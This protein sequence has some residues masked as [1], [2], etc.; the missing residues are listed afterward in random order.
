MFHW[1]SLIKTHTMS[2][3]K[4]ESLVAIY[5]PAANNF[6][7]KRPMSLAEFMENIHQLEFP[8]DILVEMFRKMKRDISHLK[9]QYREPTI[10]PRLITI[11]P[12]KHNTSNL[13]Q[14]KDARHCE[15]QCS[16]CS[17]GGPGKTYK[18]FATIFI[19]LLE[20]IRNAAQNKNSK[21]FLPHILHVL[22]NGSLEVQQKC[23][24][25]EELLTPSDVSYALLDVGTYS[26]VLSKMEN[27]FRTEVHLENEIP[28]LAKDRF[29]VMLIFQ[30]ICSFCCRDFEKM[31]IMAKNFQ[32][33]SLVPESL[34]CF[35]GQFVIHFYE[36]LKASFF[37]DPIKNFAKILPLVEESPEIDNPHVVGTIAENKNGSSYVFLSEQPVHQ[38]NE[39]SYYQVRSINQPLEDFWMIYTDE[40]ICQKDIHCK[41][42]VLHPCDKF[43]DEKT[44]YV[45]KF[46]QPLQQLVSTKVLSA[47]QIAI[48]CEKYQ[49]LLDSFSGSDDWKFLVRYRNQIVVVRDRQIPALENLMD[50]HQNYSLKIIAHC[51]D[52]KADGTMIGGKPTLAAG[53]FDICSPEALQGRGLSIGAIHFTFGSFLRIMLQLATNT[54]LETD[55]RLGGSSVDLVN[56]LMA[57]DPETRECCFHQ[58]YFTEESVQKIL[59]EILRQT[60]P[61]RK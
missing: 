51:P 47:K 36:S 8:K 27:W 23:F 52:D 30:N 7:F 44:A 14:Y 17:I 26:R 49:D 15:T 59:D 61:F 13:L 60:F 21:S 12:Y 33:Y 4:T 35:C 55:T 46:V 5:T 41:S 58:T 19:N 48:L 16:Y 18:R 6:D 50:S 42:A 11:N 39:L 31:S 37:E 38:I 45:F 28:E 24:A 53:V 29:N 54:R 9:N 32:S 1:I 3:S 40:D 25:G 20:K 2:N 56:R 43:N 10:C 34:K 22:L 57:D